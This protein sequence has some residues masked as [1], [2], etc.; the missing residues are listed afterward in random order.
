[1]RSSGSILF[2]MSSLVHG[3]AERQTI[4]LAGELARRH[5]V[6]IAYLK[7]V[8][9]LLPQVPRERL[10]DLVFLNAHDGV[11]SGA[12]RRL[13]ALID[14]HAAHTVVC[15]NSYPLLYAHLARRRANQ[16]PAIVEVYHTTKLRTLGERLRMLVY[17]PLFWL[18]DQVVYVSLNQRRYWRR[19]GLFGRRTAVIHNGVD[20]AFF[21]PP[22]PQSAQMAREHYGMTPGDRVIGIAAVLR[23]EKAHGLLLD[24]VARSK[25]AG[26]P[27]KVLIIG[28]G[29]MRGQVEACIDALDLRNDVVITGFLQDVRPA[30]NACD[31]MAIVSNAIETFSIA[32]LEAM[33]MGKPMIMSRIGGADEQVQHGV[34]GLLFPADDV[35]ALVACL[36]QCWNATVRAAMGERAR[37]DTL[38]RFSQHT[39]VAAYE[40]ILSSL[41]TG[42]GKSAS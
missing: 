36:A 42:A 29:P 6:V 11:D 30:V 16:T 4:S 13:S 9:D 25:A 38:A 26:H 1:M 2:V 5:R 31:A 21:S 28:D 12:V 23:P 7:P 15:V 18:S 22:T 27:W 14:H 8:E 24:A 37:E 20:T 33:S 32:A 3:G 10:L 17:R 34:N 35:E 41:S 40:K 39:M 19:R